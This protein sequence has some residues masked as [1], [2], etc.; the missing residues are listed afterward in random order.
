[1][2]QP[3]TLVAITAGIAGTYGVVAVAGIAGIAGVTVKN[4]QPLAHTCQSTPAFVASLATA[5]VRFAVA[6]ASICAGSEG[7][8]LTE[9]VVDGWMVMAL[10]LILTAGSA[11]EV[12]TIVTGVRVEV[13]G[14]AV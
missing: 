8:K 14:G 10:E 13:T 11:T 6:L 7:M 4:P 1:L 12:A 3:E 9:K 2:D 5:A